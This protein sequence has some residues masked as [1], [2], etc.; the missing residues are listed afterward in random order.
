MQYEEEKSTVRKAAVFEAP[1][2]IVDNIYLGRKLMQSPLIR[3]HGM[4][5][6]KGSVQ[7]DLR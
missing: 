4:A 1:D 2:H 7:R 3:I 6:T 5:N